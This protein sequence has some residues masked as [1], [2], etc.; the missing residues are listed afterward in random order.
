MLQ[1]I[2]KL[3]L[4][5]SKKY[6]STSVTFVKHLYS[7]SQLLWSLAESVL[8]LQSTATLVDSLPLKYNSLLFSFVERCQGSDNNVLTETLFF[9]YYS[10]IFR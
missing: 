9:M 1:L 4:L 10:S 8:H 5:L 7:R 6:C 2:S 3:Y